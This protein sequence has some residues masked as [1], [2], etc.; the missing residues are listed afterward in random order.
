MN[1]FE[2]VGKAGEDKGAVIVKEVG[3]VNRIGFREV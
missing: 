1:E 3:T 2:A